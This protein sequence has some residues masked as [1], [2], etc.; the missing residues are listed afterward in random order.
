MEGW[1]GF[2]DVWVC[3]FVLAYVEMCCVVLRHV[4]LGCVGFLKDRL[5]WTLLNYVTVGWIC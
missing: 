2:V 1:V 4:G 5:L 3:W